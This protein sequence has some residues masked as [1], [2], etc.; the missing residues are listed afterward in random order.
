MESR[1]RIRV[2]TLCSECIRL[3]STDGK[4]ICGAKHGGKSIFHMVSAFC[5]AGG[6]SL[7]QIRTSE[8]SNEITAVPELVKASDLDDCI[9][10]IDTT[11]YRQHTAS[12]IIRFKAGYLSEVK[13]NQHELY[14]ATED[15]FRF[16]PVKEIAGSKELN[17][18]HG[19]IENRT[20]HI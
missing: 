10:G 15:T 4:T 12:G 8:K 16:Q 14:E 7:G 19:R 3:V 13:N 11:G 17:F 6:V 18:G 20:C 5:H 2:K 9:V 1:F